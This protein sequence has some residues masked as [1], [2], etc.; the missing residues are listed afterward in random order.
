MKIQ[1]HTL[2]TVI[3]YIKNQLKGFFDEK[4]IRSIQYLILKEVLKKTKTH[5]LA[6]PEIEIKEKEFKTIVNIIS[7]LQKNEPIQYILGYT[8]FYGD[9][10]IVNKNV[11]IPRP[12]TEELVQWILKE[13]QDF[14]GNLLDIGTGS[15][16]IITTLA[17]Y[18]KSAKCHGIDKY[19]NALKIASKNAAHQNAKIE[20]H[21]YD[22]LNWKK[23]KLNQT[24]DIIVS[25]PP[26]IR[27]KEKLLMMKNVLDYEPEN[28]LFVPDKNPLLFYSTII[29]FSDEYLNDKGKIYFEINESFG[30]E[31]VETLLLSNFTEIE[32]HKDINGKDRMVRAIK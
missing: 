14:K 12:E 27:D 24:F 22:I 15:G 30:N 23:N 26:Y 25:N 16:C 9:S 20:F 3:K 28:A 1:I 6:N 5:L 7:R 11:L 32:L 8:D 21:Q 18:L 2:S 19:V 4:E 31:I 10:F 29:E 17:K 13:N